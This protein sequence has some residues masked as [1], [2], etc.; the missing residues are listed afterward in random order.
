MNVVVPH[1][2]TALCSYYHNFLIHSA[3]HRGTYLSPSTLTYYLCH[4][5]ITNIFPLLALFSE[6]VNGQLVSILQTVGGKV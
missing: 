4:L 6:L 1:S 3:L 5:F 2:S